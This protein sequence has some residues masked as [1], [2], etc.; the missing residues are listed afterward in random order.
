MSFHNTRMFCGIRIVTNQKFL[1][2]FFS[3][4]QTSNDNFNIAVRLHI[5]SNSQTR[6]FDYPACEVKNFNRLAHV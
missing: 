3:W 4:A 5:I 1:V 2:E 6:Q